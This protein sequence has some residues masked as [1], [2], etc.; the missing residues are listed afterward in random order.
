MSRILKNQVAGQNNTQSFESPFALFN[1]VVG[2][3]VF[4]E[5][6]NNKSQTPLI[7]KSTALETINKDGKLWVTSKVSVADLYKANEDEFTSEDTEIVD[8]PTSRNLITR[9]R[10]F[11]LQGAILISMFARTPVAKEFRKWAKEVLA[12]T[13]IKNEEAAQPKIQESK[14]PELEYYESYEHEVVLMKKEHFE[15]L[16]EAIGNV[17]QEI[18]YLEKALG[19]YD[20][21]KGDTVVLVHNKDRAG[22]MKPSIYTRP[23]SEKNPFE[24]LGGWSEVVS[25]LSH[26]L[27]NEIPEPK[28][29]VFDRGRMLKAS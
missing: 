26:Y 6:K 5:V 8:S 9:T 22:N 7:F 11:S 19:Y 27:L 25:N 13:M 10:Y 21:I 3:E 29:L 16:L 20:A 17:K 1:H 28:K 15:L 12:N 24:R 14:K 23:R 18:K 2:Q 4:K